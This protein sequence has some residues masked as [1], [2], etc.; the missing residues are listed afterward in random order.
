MLFYI[1]SMISNPF[2][3]SAIITVTREKIIFVVQV[4][5]NKVNSQ[6]SGSKMRNVPVLFTPTL[7]F[8]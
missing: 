3:D 7:L 1:H 6:F 4:S 2:M 5:V 8:N